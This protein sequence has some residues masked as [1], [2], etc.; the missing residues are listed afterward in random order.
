MIAGSSSPTGR[1]K[2]S[3]TWL[4]SLAQAEEMEIGK[5]RA[6][7]GQ[8]REGWRCCIDQ[9][10]ARQRTRL[11]RLAALESLF[12]RQSGGQWCRSRRRRRSSTGAR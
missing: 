12:V 10:P 8:E 1:A 9:S 4:R 7:T 3:S 2:R 6:A 11:K 5:E